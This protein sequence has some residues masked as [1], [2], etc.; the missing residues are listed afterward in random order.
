MLS[1]LLKNSSRASD[2][3]FRVGG[4]EFLILSL[5]D[6]I[7]GGEMLA[8]KIRSTLETQPVIYKQTSINMTTSIGVS[9]ADNNLGP[10]AALT[11][12]LY[13]ADKALYAAKNQGR[14]QVAI[15]DGEQQLTPS[16]RDMAS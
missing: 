11:N 16:L 7:Q 14:N 4:E 9:L 8:E 10:E 15:Y 3:V 1:Q 5:A 12:L 2:Y 13:H 6:T